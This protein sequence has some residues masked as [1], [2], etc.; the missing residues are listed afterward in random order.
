MKIYKLPRLAEMNQEGEFRLGPE[1]PLEPGLYLVYGRLRPRETG[2]RAFSP[3]GHERIV[4]VIKGN[5]NVRHGKT[6]FTVGAGEAFHAMG[7]VA[8][9]FDNPADEEAVYIAAG[10]DEK[11]APKGAGKGTGP[12]AN[13]PKEPSQAPAEEEKENPD[14]FEISRDEGPG[15]GEG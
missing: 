3:E 6:G 11:A 2:R 9:Y 7:G 15:E 12:A 14:E 8:F 13:A 10:G 1:D 5:I 4:C